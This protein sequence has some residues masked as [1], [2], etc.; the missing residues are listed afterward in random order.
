MS[1]SDLND[2]IFFA[3]NEEELQQFKDKAMKL[4]VILLDR[5]GKHPLQNPSFFNK[6]EKDKFLC[7]IREMW[8]EI[9]DDEVNKEFN[10]IVC[11]NLFT[12]GAD[13]SNYPCVNIDLPDHSVLYNKGDSI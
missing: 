10:S 7:K 8:N 1:T 3:K 11:D 4:K 9:T 5:L 2:F 6:R 12:N 13:V